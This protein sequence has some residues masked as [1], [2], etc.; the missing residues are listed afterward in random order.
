MAAMGNFDSA[1]QDAMNNGLLEDLDTA[2][3]APTSTHPA[4]GEAPAASAASPPA[5]G[6][7]AEPPSVATAAQPSSAN[8]QPGSGGLSQPPTAAGA[9][10]TGGVQ[11]ARGL[12]GAA[13]PPRDKATKKAHS[14]ASSP[15]AS[16]VSS[17]GRQSPSSRPAPSQPQQDNVKRARHGGSPPQSPAGASG[18]TAAADAA[19]A[20]AQPNSA[21]A[22][23]EI[24]QPNRGAVQARGGGG[25]LEELMSSMFGGSADGGEGLN[26][27]GLMQVR[28][29]LD[30]VCAILSIMQCKAIR[31]FPAKVPGVCGTTLVLPS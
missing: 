12:G 16:N 13:L 25:G 27:G 7:A 8:A 30:N 24:A 9:G 3:S 5:S 15:G 29:H 11:R 10:I 14:R 4:S 23:E 22:V 31:H 2:P 17:S 6:T 20:V 19:T 18:A 21:Q 26:L 28:Q 1:L